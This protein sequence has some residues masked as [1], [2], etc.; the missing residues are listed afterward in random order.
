MKL[1]IIGGTGWLGGAIAKRLLGTGHIA[2][3]NLWLSNRSG[4]RDGFE[5]WAD[6]TITSDSAALVDAC[7]VVI[8]AVRPEQLADLRV[9]ASACLVLSVMASTPMARLAELTGAR[10]IIRTMPNPGVEHGQGVTPWFASPD[11]TDSDRVCVQALFDACGQAEEVSGEDQINYL[12]GL[13]GPIPGLFGLVASVMIDAAIARGFDRAVAERAVRFHA[14]AAGNE[15]LRSDLTPAQDV[16]RTLEYG[17]TTTAG[18]RSALDASIARCL[19]DALS[20]AE[21]V[22]NRDRT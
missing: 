2:Q 14:M 8:L 9:D 1:G 6:V 3:N 10:R 12:T 18:F 22:A 16:E 21:E 4:R 19:A 7:D 15:I 5:A 13:T 17:G 11:A 20:A